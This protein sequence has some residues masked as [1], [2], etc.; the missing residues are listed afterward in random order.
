MSDVLE[1]L[2]FALTDGEYNAIPVRTEKGILNRI[3]VRPWYGYEK[4]I[5]IYCID[6]PGANLCNICR[7]GIAHIHAFYYGSRITWKSWDINHPLFLN[8]LISFIKTSGIRP[9]GRKLRRKSNDTS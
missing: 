9:K 8:R 1:L 4:L 6:K 2:Y 3:N 5:E 7:L